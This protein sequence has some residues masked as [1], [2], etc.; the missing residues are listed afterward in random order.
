MVTQQVANEVKERHWAELLA[1]PQVCGVGT[2]LDGDEWV[3]QVHIEVGSAVQ[4]PPTIDGVPVRVLEDGPYYAF[5]AD[6]SR[7]CKRPGTEAPG[8]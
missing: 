7:V 6:D 4:L 2:G 5:P 1:M 3:L 8:G